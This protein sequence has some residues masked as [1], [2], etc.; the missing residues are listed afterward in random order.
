[1]QM[2]AYLLCVLALGFSALMTQQN[3]VQSKIF[4]MLV[5]FWDVQ[6]NKTPFEDA[7]QWVRRGKGVFMSKAV[8]NNLWVIIY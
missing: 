3:I 7:V 2:N 6:H 4:Y 1:M 8:L 5:Q